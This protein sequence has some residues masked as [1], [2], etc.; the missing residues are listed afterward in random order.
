MRG[1]RLWDF[2]TGQLPCPPCPTAPE[3]PTIPEKATDEAKKELLTDFDDLMA[4]YESQFSAYNAWLDEDA[5]VGSILIASIEDQ[6]ASE[7]ADFDWSHQMWSFLRDRHEPIGHFTYFAA[8][9]QE[10][11]IRHGDLTVDELYT[12]LSATWRQIDSLRHPL[13]PSTCEFCQGHQSDIELQRTYAFLTR[14]R[15]EYEPLRAQLLARHPFVSLM[16]ALMD[17]RNEETRLRT[18]G[19]LPSATA[20]AARS[21]SSRLAV[22]PP[23]LP[24]SAPVSSPPAR[25]WGGGGLHCDYCGK[26]GHVKA[27]CY[28]KKKTHRSQTRQASKTPQVSLTSGSA[29]AR[30]SQRS[31]TDPVTRRC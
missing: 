24:S 8:I 1:L 11:L 27:F 10:Q 18:A 16:D 7:I 5:R 22:P 31:S 25:G 2:L 28:R 17:V 26:D 19:L 14:L 21:S 6:F 13:S 3:C 9:R 30:V 29:S 4:S 20:L 23:S 15:D 12:Q